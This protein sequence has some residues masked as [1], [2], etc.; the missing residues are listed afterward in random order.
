MLLTRSS[1]THVNA[2]VEAKIATL[3]MNKPIMSPE[4]EKEVLACIAQY[5]NRNKWSQWG[6]TH[7]RDQGAAVLLIGPPGTGK[8]MIATYLC[9]R[10][11]IGMRSL[12]ISSF[13]SKE[14]GTNE[15]MLDQIF[16]EAARDGK[17][18][19]IDECDS[20]L[21]DRSK[22]GPDAQWMASVINKILSEISKFKNLMFL[23]TNR[24]GVLDPALMRRL[25]AVL[26]IPRPQ[27]PERV[28]LWEQKIPKKFPLQLTR[29]QI[30]ELASLDLTGAEIENAVIRE[31]QL[32][33]SDSREP[34]FNSLCNVA[35]SESNSHVP[36]S[37]L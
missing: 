32:A 17:A 16:K 33:I 2:K 15:R 14:P 20:I 31:A 4:L 19:F 21:W 23:A 7:Y 22:A 13:G 26:E 36:A 28:R 27:Y 5:K 12:D 1:F 34:K 29:V 37:S 11:K 9:E 24:F 35:K 3:Q 10:A 6:M 18:L 25:L 8:T 30:E